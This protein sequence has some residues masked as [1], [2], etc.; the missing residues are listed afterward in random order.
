MSSNLVEEV[1]GELI[2][3]E[4]LNPPCRSL[5]GLDVPNITGELPSTKAAVG[6]FDYRW[7]PSA[8]RDAWLG[9]IKDFA[10]P[11]HD[12]QAWSRFRIEAHKAAAAVL[13]RQVLDLLLAF[14]HPGGLDAIIIDNLPTD[15]ELGPTPRDGQRP[16]TKQA[17][18]E[19]VITG[20]IE[21]MG[22][23]VFSYR[24]EKRGELFHQLVP[25]TGHE[26]TQSNTGREKFGFHTDNANI[27]FRF[28]QECLG[29]FGLRNHN[30]VCTL[31][32]TL[33][34]LKQALPS[35]LLR[36]LRYPIYQ[37]PA[38]L[39]FD[40]AGW[41][42]LSEPRPVIWMD[43]GGIDRI[44]LPRSNFAQTSPEAEKAMNELRAV[45]DTV[46]PLRVVVS[47]SR[48]LAFRDSRV[49]HGRDKVVGDRW[50][51]R[52]YFSHALTGLRA[53]TNS[54]PAEFSF[55]ARLLMMT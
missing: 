36:K 28:R 43:D 3:E 4:Q 11:N 42:V 49:L 33:D 47:P 6:G 24:Q 25:I 40:L 46:I 41:A 13:P 19:A 1:R 29:L 37:L 10:F 17:I 30:N 22:Y 34:D 39:S 20:I 21:L 27:P 53:E 52:V 23:E 31:I 15:D 2:P 7:F 8:A 38:P 14:A 32:L 48:F 51:Q 35:S 16:S 50:L 18:S 26:S 55:D 9:I 5:V 45:L 54:H 44:A 12:L